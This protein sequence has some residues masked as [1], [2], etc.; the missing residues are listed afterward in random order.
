VPGE[1]GG[2]YVP[3]QDPEAGELTFDQ[4]WGGQNNAGFYNADYQAACGTALTSL[5]GQPAY[6]QAH[7]DAQTIFS[8][9]LPVAP[10]FLRLKLA[11]TRTD[12]CNF[13]TDPTENSEMWNI[14]EFDYGPACE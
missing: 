12:M 13:I 11:A 14:E 8:E 10:L 7:L 1:P 3:I 6:D 9:Q 4:G 2:T 5:P